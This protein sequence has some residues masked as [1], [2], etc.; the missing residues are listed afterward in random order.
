MSDNE[1]ELLIRSFDAD[2]GA[3]DRQALDRVLDGSAEA[4]AER[5]RLRR[6]RRIAADARADSFGPH[7]ADRVMAGLDNTSRAPA[8]PRESAADRSALPH[9]RRRVAARPTRIAAGFSAAA[10]VV[11]AVAVVLWL[12]P[13]TVTV[14]YGSMQTVELADGSVVELSSGSRLTYSNFIGR[15]ERRVELE[16]EAFFDVAHAERPFI[17]ETFNASVSVLGTR[18][19]VRAWPKDA[20]PETAVAVASG[21]VAVESLQPPRDAPETSAPATQ[22]PTDKVV[23]EPGQ[24]TSV[25]RDST[26]VREPAFVT[27]DHVVAWRSG[28]MAFVDQPVGSVFTAIE[29]RFNVDVE[30]SHPGIRHRLLTYLNPQPASAE[31]V[32][33]DVCHTLNLRYRRTANG[34]AILPSSTP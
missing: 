13:R 14:P 16:G 20:I 10:V 8:A 25:V 2:L 27:L 15:D 7:F 11:A 18:F 34:F 3:S 6:L 12:Q 24:S 33:S 22:R 1:M 28:G 17:V 32:L 19:N 30:V 29:R 4:R 21:R 31:E 23:L 5:E 26:A 9:I